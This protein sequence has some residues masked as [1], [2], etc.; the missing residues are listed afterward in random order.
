MEPLVRIS[1]EKAK[2]IV[3]CI[4]G[5]AQKVLGNSTDGQRADYD[6]LR[7]ILTKRFYPHDRCEF[8][9]RKR[10]RGENL[11]DNGYAL[12][13]LGCL[14]FPN[15]TVDGRKMFLSSL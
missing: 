8:R 9:S 7:S 5:E 3:T 13:R 12:R 2:Q 10:E 6:N 14:A 4:R 15:M 11:S 1:H